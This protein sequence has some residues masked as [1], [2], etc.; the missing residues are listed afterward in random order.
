MARA[1]AATEKMTR[2]LGPRD[3]LSMSVLWLALSLH[4][5]ALLGIVLQNRVA[6]FVPADRQGT[7][8]AALLGIGAFIST[9]LQLAI[10]TLS[11]RSTHGWGRRRPYIF[12]GVLLNTIPLLYFAWARSFGGLLLAFIGVQICLN[13][14]NGPYQALIP[15]LVPRDRHG[16][17]SAY[18]GLMTLIGQAMGLALPGLLV[19]SNPVL[20]KSWSQTDRLFLVTGALAVAMLIAMAI[21]VTRVR[22]RRWQPDPTAPSHS[23]REMFAIRPSEYP[24]FSWLIVSRFFINLGFYTATAFLLFYVRDSLGMGNQAERYTFGIMGISTIAGLLGNWPA[25]VLSDRISK[26]RVIYFSCGITMLAALVFL[27]TR[28]IHVALATGFLFGAG[29]GAFCAVDWAL[30]CNLLPEGSPAKYMGI[31]HFAFTVPQIVAPLLV[32]P[33]ADRVNAQFGMGVGWRLAMMAIIVYLAIGTATIS[34]IR[35]RVADRKLPH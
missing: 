8:L 2:D 3:Y 32:G 19:G 6:A 11:D 17:A 13:I 24:D 25:G 10:G 16:R 35:E 5:G 18:M 28:S 15:D 9:V 20:L 22:E 21:T 14:A 33:L 30:A 7:Y 27:L 34:R 1:V 12:W 31:W 23:W 4:W 29:Y 26:K